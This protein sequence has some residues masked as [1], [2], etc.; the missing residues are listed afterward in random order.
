MTRMLRLALVLATACASAPVS[1]VMAQSGVPDSVHHR[2]DCRLAHQVLVHGR[3]ANKRSW[4]L[5]RLPLCGS[6]SV[7][8]LQNYLNRHRSDETYERTLDEVVTA[9]FGLVD[10]NLAFAALSI[11]KS[12]ASGTAARIQ[13]LRLLYAQVRP[14]T[15]V[16]VQGFTRPEIVS[17]TM[18]ADGSQSNRIEPL[19]PDLVIDGR[20]VFTVTP[21]GAGDA[22]QIATELRILAT[23]ARHHQ[24]RIGA[25][26]AA[27]AF[28]SFARCPPGATAQQCLARFRAEKN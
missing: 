10:R 6:G 5:A 13:A 15:S 27:A 9:S 12:E 16:S 4:A 7:E 22:E 2:N 20:A 24:V 18:G 14:T 1:P 19:D 17:V 25:E 3:P 23:G 8:V 11:A 26:R 28:Q 21:L